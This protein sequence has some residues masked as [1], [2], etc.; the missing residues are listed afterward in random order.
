MI[1][2][3]GS[4]LKG[5]DLNPAFY[6]FQENLPVEKLFCVKALSKKNDNGV[7]TIISSM[8]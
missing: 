2:M 5:Y 1:R 4:C 8:H 7:K 6:V 3:V